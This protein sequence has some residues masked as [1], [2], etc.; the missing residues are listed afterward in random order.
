[1]SGHSKWSKIKHGKMATDKKRGKTF[2]KHAKLV[3]VAARSGGDP[4]MNPTLR[5]AIENARADNVP[6]ENIDRAI[7]KGSGET[8][9]AANIEE[10]M[11]EGFGPGGTALYIQALTDNRNRTITNLKI[12]MGKH[13]GTMGAS[14]SVGYL[15]ERKGMIEV[16]VSGGNAE[17]VELTAIDAGALDIEVLDD[18][19]LVTTRDKDLM[20]VK[21]V[22]SDA[23]CKCVSAELAF[24]PITAMDVSDEDMEKLE[25][26][27]ETLEDDDDVLNVYTNAG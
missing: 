25:E 15:F 11:Y 17:A 21:K 3:E 20:S 2:T 19:V 1:M 12:I 6:Y 13:G 4:E 9:G 23:G 10:V 27:V 8:K 26:L 18:T 16:D 22:V 14:G 5:A 7:K 24:L